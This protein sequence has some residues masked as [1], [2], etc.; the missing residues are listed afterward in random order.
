M[1]TNACRDNPSAHV[2]QNQESRSDITCM[3]ND[4]QIAP[5]MLPY[6]AD[7]NH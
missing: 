1:A 7:D 3:N 5:G 4:R 2:Y 6:A